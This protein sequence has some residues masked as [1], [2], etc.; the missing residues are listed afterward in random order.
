MSLIGNVLK[1]LAKSVLMLLGLAAAS[2][3]DTAIHKKIFGSGVH[4]SDLALL[5]TSNEEMNGNMKIVRS[6][7]KS[8]LLIKSLCQIIKNE[9]KEEKRGFLS[10]LFDKVGAS[11]L[12]N[13][14][15]CKGAIAMSQGRCTITR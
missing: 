10:M 6:L 9:S 14:S 13:L 5:T 7:E 12:R 8:G 11:L 15:T 2:A 4:P 3:A 1:S